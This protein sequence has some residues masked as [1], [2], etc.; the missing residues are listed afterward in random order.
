MDNTLEIFELDDVVIEKSNI[1]LN[2]GEIE[3]QS[4][5]VSVPVNK[6]NVDILKIDTDDFQTARECT[7]SV[8]RSVLLSSLNID[9]LNVED[10]S[11]DCTLY[12]NKQIST[13]LQTPIRE[14]FSSNAIPWDAFT[15][16]FTPEDACVADWNHWLGLGRDEILM[17]SNGANNHFSKDRA[18]FTQYVYDEDNESYKYSGIGAFREFQLHPTVNTFDLISNL[19]LQT[20]SSSINLVNVDNVH[21]GQTHWIIP[22]SCNVDPRNLVQCCCWSLGTKRRNDYTSAA[23]TYRNGRFIIPVAKLGSHICSEADDRSITFTRDCRIQFSKMH[24][25]ADK[26]RLG[27][28]T[29]LIRGE[30]V[31]NETV[32]KLFEWSGDDIID[33]GAHNSVQRNLK[34]FHS[35]TN[36]AVASMVEDVMLDVVDIQEGDQLR[37]VIDCTDGKRLNLGYFNLVLKI[38]YEEG[39]YE[40]SGSDWDQE[41]SYYS[42]LKSEDAY[43]EEFFT[44]SWNTS[45]IYDAFDD[46]LVDFFYD[47]FE[48]DSVSERWTELPVYNFYNPLVNIGD[49]TPLK[50]LTDICVANDYELVELED[51]TLSLSDKIR[52]FNIED[53]ELTSIDYLNDSFGQATVVAYSTGQKTVAYGNENLEKEKSIYEL[54]GVPAK[55]VNVESYVN[56]IVSIPQYKQEED[57]VELVNDDNYLFFNELMMEQAGYYAPQISSFTYFFDNLLKDTNFSYLYHFTVQGVLENCNYVMINGLI[58]Y[59]KHMNKDLKENKTNLEVFLVNIS[60]SKN[61][62]FK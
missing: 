32:I 4:F 31:R 22:G 16:V 34:G 41:M 3:E 23:K 12:P 58:Y 2:G 21:N 56:R 47:Y 62:V 18:Y 55:L 17:Y 28:T 5:N 14:L 13:V 10:N 24:C 38:L 11:L 35:F 54:S 7:A 61:I 60:R 42:G 59:V 37:I 33:T 48:Q 19:R 52:V 46:P 29:G 50:L 9:R 43:Y 6:H 40:I 30:L 27:A 45:D 25:F 44:N 53:A 20:D 15:Y 1:I 39:S 36:M 57:K 8:D 51:G 49:V 26:Y